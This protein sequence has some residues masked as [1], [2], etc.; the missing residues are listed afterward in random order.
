[1]FLLLV[2]LC[3]N[4]LSALATFTNNASAHVVATDPPVFSARSRKFDRS[5]MESTE[6]GEFKSGI[7]LGIIGTACLFCV[8]GSDWWMNYKNL[9]AEDVGLRH[10]INETREAERLQIW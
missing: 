3:A 10:E 2:P 4:T 7:V 5:L 6:G 1:M 9:L 8:A